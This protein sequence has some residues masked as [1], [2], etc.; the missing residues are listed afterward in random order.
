MR[1]SK[2]LTAVN[3]IDIHQQLEKIHCFIYFALIFNEYDER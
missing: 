2:R 1:R 3:P